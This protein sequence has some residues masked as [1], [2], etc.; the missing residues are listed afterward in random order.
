[1]ESRFVIIFSQGVMRV[2]ADQ[3]KKHRRAAGLTQS[4][5][6]EEFHVATGTIGMWETGKREPNSRTLIKLAHFFGI[7]VDDLL[8]GGPAG[9]GEEAGAA[10]RVPVYAA[11]RA[12]Q[13]G[14][15]LGEVV[16]YEAFPAAAE[17]SGVYFGLR[18]PDG[19]MYPEYQT[20]DIVIARRQD[21]AR[22]GED[23]V[24]S[25]GG[26]DAA[27]RRIL[28]GGF[29]II[30]FHTSYYSK[31]G[32]GCKARYAFFP[33]PA[34]ADSR[35]VRG[36][37][38]KKGPARG[39]V[40]KTRGR[41]SLQRGR[42]LALG[43]KAIYT[44]GWLGMGYGPRFSQIVGTGSPPSLRRTKGTQWVMPFLFSSKVNSAT[45]R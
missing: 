24:V 15:A 9:H 30:Q 34:G 44:R 32:G 12:G 7:S 37:A 35:R 28:R 3:I 8:S 29:F 6:A 42:A 21:S 45:N 26:E 10:G 38:P 5:F 17:K 39:Q 14:E 36:D 18:I 41:P 40:L 13:P 43:G 4:Q 22:D 33:R 19:A 31:A 23:V 1:M 11:L 25:V 16:G 2:L 20:G 27:L